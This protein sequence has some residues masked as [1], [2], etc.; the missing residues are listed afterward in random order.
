MAQFFREHGKSQE[1]MRIY[2]Y[3]SQLIIT[4]RSPFPTK[5]KECE[6]LKAAGDALMDASRHSEAIPF[7]RESLGRA[8]PTDAGPIFESLGEAHAAKAEYHKAKHYFDK[9]L[10]ICISQLDAT[11]TECNALRDNLNSVSRKIFTGSA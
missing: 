7:L 11:S 3:L 6:V 2:L 4:D 1:A 9:A 8:R 5:G 10:S